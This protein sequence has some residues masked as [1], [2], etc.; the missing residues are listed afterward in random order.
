[1]IRLSGELGK[2]AVAAKL[3]GGLENY[4][5]VLIPLPTKKEVGCTGQ[6]CT[7]ILTLMSPDDEHTEISLTKPKEPSIEREYKCNR[8][9]LV[10][11][12]WYHVP[13]EVKE[14]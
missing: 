4:R 6:Y 13:L 10:K 2:L 1:M 11:V 7:E 12:Y 3:L 9:H 8:G 14:L 5:V